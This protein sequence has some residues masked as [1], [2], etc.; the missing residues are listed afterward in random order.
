M[1]ATSN[2]AASI[3]KR[4]YRGPVKYELNDRTWA[5]KNFKK[6][7]YT[8]NGSEVIVPVHTSR[9]TGVGFRSELN[10]ASSGL[11]EAGEQGFQNL[12]IPAKYFYGRFQLSGP[13][14]AK[15]KS[16]GQG[17]FL[18]LLKTE[19]D[20]LV[21]DVSMNADSR[22]VTGGPVRGLLC[23]YKAS[24]NTT[25]NQAAATPA[26]G[27]AGWAYDGDY[28]P[29][30]S[31][32]TGTPAT[33]VRVKL[34]RQDTYAEVTQVGT[35]P[36]IFVTNIPTAALGGGALGTMADAGAIQLTYCTNTGVAGEA[37]TT[38]GIDPGFAIA[39]QV[40]ET[41]AVDA[42]GTPLAM[43]RVVDTVGTVET[44][45]AFA[46]EGDVATCVEPSGMLTN[47]C[48]SLH[49]G[50][51]R[52]DGA[53]P[54]AT[55]L[56]SNV[57]VQDTAGGGRADLTLARIQAIMDR[58]L[59]RSGKEFTILA[60]SPLQRSQYIT[61]LTANLRIETDGNVKKGAGGLVS[62]EKGGL[63]YGG[64]RIWTSQH[65]PNGMWFLLTLDSWEMA[66]LETGDFADLDGAIL[67]RNTG[68]DTWEGFWRMYY[69]TYTASPNCNAAVAGVSL[70]L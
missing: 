3:L 13:A 40:H 29:F 53:T 8:W 66:T 17:A 59:L 38:V 57:H 51:N 23:E 27:S 43:G 61:L 9:N 7:S 58:V 15:A 65:I 46:T 18:N 32:V 39:V 31:V 37:F 49:F 26:G 54:D 67:S 44:F 16:A 41:Q 14:M 4:W 70:F 5:F 45:P 35:N 34:I 28:A 19:M 10:A 11:P 1:P 25:G 30:L 47:M 20:R 2:T 60:C 69:N 48:T 68:F 24:G 22:A 56:Q 62:T 12:S 52:A 50:I 6:S 21:I 42:A 55:I 63:T 64:L 36:N 33:W